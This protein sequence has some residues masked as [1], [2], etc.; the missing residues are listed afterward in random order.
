ML[1]SPGIVDS[2]CNCQNSLSAEELQNGN[3]GTEYYEP[4]VWQREVAPAQDSSAKQQAEEWAPSEN[5]LIEQRDHETAQEIKPNAPQKAQA[6]DTT[7]KESDTDNSAAT[8]LQYEVESHS[9]NVSKEPETDSVQ[10]SARSNTT[11]ATQQPTAETPAESPAPITPPDPVAVSAPSVMQDADRDSPIDESNDTEEADMELVGDQ[12]VLVEDFVEPNPFEAELN[13]DAE[14]DSSESRVPIPSQIK[15]WDDREFDKQEFKDQ[16][17]QRDAANKPL[18]LKARPIPGVFYSEPARYARSNPQPNFIPHNVHR[19]NLSA[20]DILPQNENLNYTFR[21]LP[22]FSQP[23]S[24]PALLASRKKVLYSTDNLRPQIDAI[25]RKIDMM[26]ELLY[27][28]TLRDLQ[29]RERVLEQQLLNQER[30][31]SFLPHPG[32][33]CDL[34][35]TPLTNPNDFDSTPQSVLQPIQAKPAPIVQQQKKSII[36]QPSYQKQN[37]ILRLKA[38]AYPTSSDGLPPI[39]NL[40]NVSSPTQQGNPE[41]QEVEPLEPGEIKIQTVCA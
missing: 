4:H 26:Q 21:P 35:P 36:Q 38:Y 22:P 15:E 7:L 9:A 23:S 16:Q 19:P 32:D 13:Q 31:A 6:S 24:T 8:P 1:T 3:Q 39:I 18:T 30:D 37:Q 28:Q 12:S 17:E 41:A 10:P 25:S 27:E 40:R 33:E 34:E 5:S 20:V 29:Y 14:V 11:S 2:N